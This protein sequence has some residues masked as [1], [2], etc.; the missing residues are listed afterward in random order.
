METESNM[1]FKDLIVRRVPK[2]S[3]RYERAPHVKWR[4][5]EG[6]AVL[7]DANEGL[8]MHLNDVGSGIWQG[9]DG[10]KSVDQMISDL[11]NAFD[12]TPHRLRKDALKFLRRLSLMELIR[13]VES[14]TV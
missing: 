9:L 10:K 12:A 8:F 13:K 14:S 6:R 4:L 3:E 7:I 5:L 1:G 2:A 11:D